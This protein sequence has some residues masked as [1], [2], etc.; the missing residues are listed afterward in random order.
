M[1]MEAALFKQGNYEELWQRCCGFIDLSLDD[2]MM[3]QQRLLLEQLELL[4]GCELGRYIMNG[5]NPH[6]V[7]ELRER[8]SESKSPL[9]PMLITLPTS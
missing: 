2:F 7:E 5:A 6:N 9:P 1:T 3:I 8:N 4:K